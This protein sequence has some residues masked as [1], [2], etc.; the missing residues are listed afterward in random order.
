[1][2]RQVRQISYTKNYLGFVLANA[3]KTDS[4]LCKSREVENKFLRKLN[5]QET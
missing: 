2:H 4:R 1:M 3:G 5:Q